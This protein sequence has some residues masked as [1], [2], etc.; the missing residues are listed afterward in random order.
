MLRNWLTQ[1]ENAP[2][3][4]CAW[5]GSAL[6]LADDQGEAADERLTG[7]FFRETRYLS[8]LALRLNGESPFRC[9]AARVDANKLE[10]TYI[11]PALDVGAGGGSGSAGQ[12]RSRGILRRGIDIKLAYYVHPSWLD[13]VL[14]AT[15]RWDES[16]E[17]DIAWEVAADYRDIPEV[18][19]GRREQD[20]PVHAQRE[21]SGIRFRYAHSSLPYE[22]FIGVTG[23]PWDF[24]GKQIHSR[25]LL[26]RQEAHTVS[27]RILANDFENPIDVDEGARRE[28]RLHSWSRQTAFVSSSAGN[29]FA[30]LVNCGL[31]DVGSLSL[32]E[33]GTDEWLTPAAGVPLY[34]ALWGRDALTAVWQTAMFD[35]GEMACSALT[36]IGRMQGRRVDPARDEEPGRIIQQARSGPLD[37]LG[38]T[39]FARYYADQASPF[40]FIFAL[41]HAYA[42]RGELELVRRH[43]DTA[44]GIL[45]WARDYGDLDRDGF[46]EYRTQSKA[47]PKHQGWKDSDNAIVYEDGRQVEPPVA[48]CEVQAYYFAALQIMAV[49]SGLMKDPAHAVNCWRAA[50]DLKR[51]FNAAFWLPDEGFIALALDSEKKPVRS[52]TSNAGQCIAAGI[53]DVEHLP[54]LVRRLFDPDMFS[55]WGIRTL[56]TTNPAYNPLDYHLGSVWLVENSTIVF[57][58]RRFGFDE[59]AIQLA[60]AL[61][62]L[63]LLWP[64]MR[65]PECVGGYSRDEF[66]HPGAYPRANA[67][68]MW[69]QSAWPLILQTLLG[70]QPM[71]PLE[72]LAVDPILPDWLPDVTLRGLQVGNA[73]VNLRFARGG[74]GST[75]TEILSKEG[76]LHI[77]RQPSPNSLRTGFGDRLSAFLDRPVARRW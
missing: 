47:G 32:L 39:P 51:R 42:C 9:S 75:T 20:A 33:G 29:S 12:S 35:H 27:L 31:Q 1:A 15:S 6:L 11:Y 45:D 54:L 68:Q 69:N 73:A 49:L 64:G 7:F 57:G 30:G 67:P 3:L 74:D 71:A 56:S 24:D 10:F 16:A 23:L 40:D 77:V 18:Q 36:R 41:A 55:G 13:V 62:D 43:W 17:L 22:T 19:S 28:E 2:R 26:K 60:K 4:F 76:V 21:D 46:L 5:R 37:R 38:R 65:V 70:L 66:A 52:L 8:R 25:L 59:R 44:T 34:L 50:G 48:A 53:V 61:Y 14:I 63:A 58:L 72:T